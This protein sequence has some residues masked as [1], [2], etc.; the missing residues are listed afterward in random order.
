MRVTHAPSATRRFEFVEGTSSKFW[1][2]HQE[3]DDVVIRFG[4]IGTAGQGVRKPFKDG[5]AASRHIE[6]LIHEKISKG[7]AEVTRGN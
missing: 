5:A 6:K 2:V 7:Y 1:E 4:R 3:G